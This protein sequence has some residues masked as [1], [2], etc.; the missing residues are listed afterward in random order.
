M[1]R[2]LSDND[3]A[4]EAVSAAIVVRRLFA[5]GGLNGLEPNA[6]QVLLTLKLEPNRTVNELATVLALAKTTVSHSVSA[7]QQ[8]GL[9]DE[10]ADDR[11]RRRRPQRL[12]ADGEHLAAQL[13]KDIRQRL[14]AIR[15]G[16]ADAITADTPH[17]SPQ[18]H[19]AL[20][21]TDTS[22]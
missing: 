13:V 3:V 1:A 2:K 19:P 16:D 15:A 12:T 10:S 21:T 9:L 22:P 7:L 8:Q 5:R 17:S 20:T 11:D 6:V 14:G 18:G 4:R